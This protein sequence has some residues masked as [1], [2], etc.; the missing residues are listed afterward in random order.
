MLKRAIRCEP[1]TLFVGA[2][3]VALSIDLFWFVHDYS[4]DM[5]LGD[6]I[7][8]LP[9]ATGE[10]PVDL[11][12]LW[13]EHNNH[14][15]LL[16]RLLYLALWHLLGPSFRWGMYFGAFALTAT[17]TLFVLAAQRL[18]GHLSYADAFFPLLWLSRGHAELLLSAF[19][20]T[21]NILTLL[22]LSLLAVAISIS[23]DPLGHRGLRR[24]I[25]FATIAAPLTTA[26]GIFVSAALIPWLSTSAWK[27]WRQERRWSKEIIECSALIASVVAI[28]VAHLATLDRHNAF[29]EARFSRENVGQALSMPFGTFLTAYPRWWPVFFMFLISSIV[30][31][32]VASFARLRASNRELHRLSGL[33]SIIGGFVVTAGMIG[34]ARSSLGENAGLQTRYGLVLSPLLGC[35]YLISQLSLGKSARELFQMVLF[36]TSASVAWPTAEVGNAWREWRGEQYAE[37]A[38]GVRAGWTSHDIEDAMTAQDFVLKIQG[39]FLLEELKT[40]HLGPFRAVTDVPTITAER[41]GELLGKVQPS[42]LLGSVDSCES[43]LVSFVIDG[44]VICP[45]AQSPEELLAL[46][47]HGGARQSGPWLIRPDVKALRGVERVGFRLWLPRWASEEPISVVAR[48]GQVLRPVSGSPIRC[49]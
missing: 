4:L 6:E 19:N 49:K 39:S 33:W 27:R 18:R 10:L 32:A 37:I 3:L 25:A 47:T 11:K 40:H 36:F 45:D 2:I 14:R 8:W 13:S 16:P 41:A 26:T 24:T 15:V 7:R 30:F 21:C 5:P 34:I 23:P 31:L 35:L 28:I 42:P 1:R 38:R 48:C 29:G 46:A 12:W 9:Y 20:S 44:W 22:I 17:A 43:R